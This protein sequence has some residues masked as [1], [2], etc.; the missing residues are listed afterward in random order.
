M[1]TTSSRPRA[2]TKAATRPARTPD[3]AG[4]PKPA[5]KAGKP[6]KASKPAPGKPAHAQ[7]DTG[8]SGAG[9]PGEGGGNAAET[10]TDLV[11]S[12][13]PHPKSLAAKGAWKLAKVIA[14]RALPTGSGSG[15]LTTL[16]AAGLK[17]SAH[18]AAALRA[19][20]IE[21][22][23]TSVD[24]VSEHRPPVQVSAEIA[25]PVDVVWGQWMRLDFLPEGVDSVVSIDRHDDDELSG[26]L[27]SNRTGW[28][29]RIL[30]ER[31]PESFAWESTA[32]SDCAGLITFHALSERL[33]RVELGLDIRP[34]GLGQA[35][36]L[37]VRRADRRARAD[38]RRFKA[39]VELISPDAY[40]DGGGD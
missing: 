4:K 12:A 25:A 16:P 5:S 1:A 34:T 35:A 14:K 39:R 30:D 27:R 22:A 21:A 32:G 3:K 9:S 40:P 33:T 19:K 26:R 36:A 20:A 8:G 29:A 7:P 28:S 23:G 17:R 24:P 37:T 13:A 2:G 31:A 10:V 18:A 15:A 38:L 6:R 11:H